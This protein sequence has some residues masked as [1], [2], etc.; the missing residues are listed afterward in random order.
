M[1]LQ[2]SEFGHDRFLFA[3]RRTQRILGGE[4]DTLRAWAL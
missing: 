2:G 1:K 4:Y 3:F